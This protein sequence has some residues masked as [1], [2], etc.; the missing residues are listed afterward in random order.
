MML[1]VPVAS[2]MRLEEQRLLFTFEIRDSG[3]LGLT[4]MTRAG[5]PGSSNRLLS[6]FEELGTQC[7]DTLLHCLIYSVEKNL[8][9]CTSTVILVL[10]PDINYKV[11]L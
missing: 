7:Y 1:F 5:H 9:K 10:S 3:V 11:Y 8:L 4:Q 6:I 2:L